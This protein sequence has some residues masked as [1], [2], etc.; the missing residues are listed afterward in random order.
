LGRGPRKGV[1]SV[2]QHVWPLATSLKQR[3]FAFK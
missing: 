3:Q 1:I 2:E